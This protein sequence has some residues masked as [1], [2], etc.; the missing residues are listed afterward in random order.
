MSSSVQ[1]MYNLKYLVMILHSNYV[2]AYYN[3]YDLI[4]HFDGAVYGLNDLNDG[5]EI[6]RLFEAKDLRVTFIDKILRTEL[7]IVQSELQYYKLYETNI[8]IR[9]SRG[10]I[11]LNY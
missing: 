9:T 3:A 6:E 10:S 4:L 11:N 1:Q 7:E 2:A 8:Y 5:D